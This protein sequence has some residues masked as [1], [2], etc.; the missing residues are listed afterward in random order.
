[1]VEQQQPQPSKPQPPWQQQQ[2]WQQPQALA[3]AALAAA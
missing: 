3:A 1:V 2:P